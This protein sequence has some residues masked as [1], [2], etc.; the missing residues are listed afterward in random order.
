LKF[1]AIAVLCVLL[2]G[3]PSREAQED[4]AV[5][6]AIDVLRD[7]PEDDLVKRRSLIDSLA[8]LP[9]TSELG[10]E[11][12]DACADAY[13]LIVESKEATTK[14][15][16]AL[17]NGELP[18]NTLADLALAGE[19]IEKSEPAMKACQKAAIELGTKRR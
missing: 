18:K 11:A 13:R 15:K 7:S 9:A 17:A 10:R 1:A 4:R 16:L 3:C 8:K 19:K 14:V 12:R 5:L 6:G 2:A